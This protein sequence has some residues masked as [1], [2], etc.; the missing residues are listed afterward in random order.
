[1]NSLTAP[2]PQERLANSRKAIVRH[3]SR[4]AQRDDDQDDGAGSGH[5]A[6]GE[7][8]NSEGGAWGILK[9]ALGAWWHHH[10]VSVAFGLAKPTLKHY[11]EEKPLQLLGIAAAAGAAAVVLRPWRLVSIGSLLIATLKS[12][13]LSGALLSMLSSAPPSSEQNQ[14][15]R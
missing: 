8:G 14:R 3:M 4:D 1:M 13:E 7:Q 6:E 5:G 2:T 10:P 11:A 12:S 9:H 15:S